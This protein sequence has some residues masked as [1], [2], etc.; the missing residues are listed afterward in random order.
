MRILM[1]LSVAALAAAAEPKLIFKNAVG[2]TFAPD[3]NTAWVGGMSKGWRILESK[4]SGGAWSEPAPAA[5]SA[6]ANDGNPFLSP[7]GRQLFFWSL[8]PIGGQPRKQAAIWMV[9]RTA[10]GWGTPRDAGAPVNT[11]GDPS[12]NPA[13][14]SDG[15]LYFSTKRPDSIGDLDLY[16]S[17]RIGVGYAEPENLGAAINSPVHEFDVYV[18]PGGDYIIFSSDRPGGAGKADLYISVRKDGAWTP[19]RNLGPEVNSEASEM[20]PAVSPGGG[21]LYFTRPGIGV[22]EVRFDPPSLRVLP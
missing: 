11:P 3:G 10:G 12:A 5:F 14:S 15:T 17:R 13:V 22:F 2:V 8:R 19:A 9:E 7:D 20:C 18:A 1:V 21:N 4:L 16:R 6:D